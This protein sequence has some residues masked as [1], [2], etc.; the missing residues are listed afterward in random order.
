MS[1]VGRLLSFIK[2]LGKTVL[3]YGAEKK[4]PF[5]THI[6]RDE[7]QNYTRI[8]SVIYGTRI[9]LSTGLL[10]PNRSQKDV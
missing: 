4:A 7:A 6:L 1:I 2:N 9:P 8:N 3:Y 5:D 10:M